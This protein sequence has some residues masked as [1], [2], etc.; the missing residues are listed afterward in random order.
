VRPVEDADLASRRQPF[1]VAAQEVLVELAVRRNLEALDPNT[2][3]VDTTHHV[4]DRPILAR[5][6]ECLK[7]YQD[8]VR[9]LSREPRLVIGKQLNAILQ[10]CGSVLLLLDSRL[11]SRIEVL[12][13]LY[14][15]ARA[16]AERLNKPRDSLRDVVSH[17]VLLASKHLLGGR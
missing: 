16:Y 7:H 2:L 3:R 15:R 10:Q 1:L 4:A 13:Q 6:V 12:C 17:R 9:I 11:E 14:A 5:S 8:A